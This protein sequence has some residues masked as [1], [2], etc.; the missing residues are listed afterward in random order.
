VRTASVTKQRMQHING[1]LLFFSSSSDCRG[2]KVWPNRGIVKDPIEE[3]LLLG[4]CSFSL[5][6]LTLRD[7]HVLS[8]VQR[9][10]IPD[11]LMFLNSFSSSQT[12]NTHAL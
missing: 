11:S 10:D 2:R 3:S 8:D 1:V 12:P 4:N 6:H 9:A 7:H 5:T